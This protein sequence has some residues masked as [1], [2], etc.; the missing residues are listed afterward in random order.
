[1]RGFALMKNQAFELDG[2]LHRIE[3]IFENGSITIENRETSLLSSVSKKELL[4]AYA[5][6][7][8]VFVDKDTG[9]TPDIALGDDA[10]A[11]YGRPFSELS[12]EIQ[13][14]ALRRK[15]YVDILFANGRPAFTPKVI[16]KYIEQAA[17]ALRDKKPPSPT[18][19]YRWYRAITT[20]GDPRKLIPRHDLRG[21]REPRTDQRVVD[22][23][24]ESVVEASTITRQWS[25]KDV[26]ARL[27]RKL[28]RENH[29]LPAEQHFKLPSPRTLYRLMDRIPEY[30]VA[31]LK[32]GKAAADRRC[33][34]TRNGVKV[35]RVLERV[36][37]DHTPLDVF[38]IDQVTGLPCGRPTLTMLIDVYS[39]MPL[40][41]YISFD[42]TSTLA[43]MRAVRHALLPKRRVEAVV[44]KVHVVHD[45]PCHGRFEVLVCDNGAE[46]HSDSLAAACFDLRIQLLFCPARQPRFKGTVER[47]LKTCNYGFAH[48][49]PGASLAH[50][51]ER[52]DYDPLKHAVLTI[53][54]FTHLLE[55]WML[56]DY[57]QSIH[58]NL[59]TT[60]WKKWHEGVA[61][62]SQKLPRSV[63]EIAVCLG[64]DAVRSLRHDGIQLNNVQYVSDELLAIIRMHGE[65]VRVRVTSDPENVGSIWL[66]PPGE[67]ERIRVPAVHADYAEGLRLAQHRMI[68]KY[69]RDQEDRGEHKGLMEARLEIAD[70]ISLGAFSKRLR[71]RRKAAKL[72]G[73]SNENP[74]GNAV[75]VAT[76]SP[77]PRKTRPAIDLTQ[78][79]RKLSRIQRTII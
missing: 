10:R 75:P 21:P 77:P 44:P 42:D 69:R 56:D 45:W 13:I 49:L 68:L 53:A 65:G 22:L 57:A 48:K 35:S 62:V 14:A 78:S 50:F 26:A 12:P 40:G 37:I 36:E 54:E 33:R 38:V 63:E 3:Q 43:V 8:F 47:F 24:M 28:S 31:V 67:H 60:P 2:V 17:L 79:G 30:D 55:K 39:R 46:F 74:S 1:M 73:V 25:M 41:Y 11:R 66:W 6:G 34:I 61:S 52:G 19:L 76:Q 29:F 4:A 15:A 9:S 18:T 64:V 59:G 7:R 5:E 23:Y 71:S 51:T 70:A 27:A 20:S 72:A 58:R 32:D 16:W